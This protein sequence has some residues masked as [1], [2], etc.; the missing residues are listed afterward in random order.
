MRTTEARIRK[1]YMF[2]NGVYPHKVEVD[3]LTTAEKENVSRLFK[4]DKKITITHRVT[5]W[6]NQ[7]NCKT[8]LAKLYIKDDEITE[9]FMYTLNCSRL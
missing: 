7:H 9:G 5:I 1:W 3:E 6:S 4:R 8:Y 2:K